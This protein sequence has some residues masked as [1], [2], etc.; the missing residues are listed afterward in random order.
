MT[1][2]LVS[3]M[4]R[5]IGQQL[6][7]DLVRATAALDAA[8]QALAAAQASS[9][10]RALNRARVG[11]GAAEERLHD[12]VRAEARAARAGAGVRQ[13]LMEVV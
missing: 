2:I 9:D 12:L 3:T 5:T 11:L 6:A 10:R 8:R 7:A 4:C 13:V 1:P